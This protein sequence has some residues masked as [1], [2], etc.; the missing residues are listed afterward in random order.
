MKHTAAG[1][2][3]PF[4]IRLRNTGM[5]TQS[6]TGRNSPPKTPKSMDNTKFFENIFSINPSGRKIWMVEDRRTPKSKKGI[7][8]KK[9]P[10]KTE[11]A[12]ITG[13]PF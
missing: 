6:Q 8:C 12:F 7:A 2:G 1:S 9:I 13:I 10:I 4:L 5:D 11:N 3:T